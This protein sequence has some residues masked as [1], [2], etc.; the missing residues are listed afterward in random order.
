[1]WHYI[2]QVE[3]SILL[4]LQRVLV[5]VLHSQS[6]SAASLNPTIVDRF[7]PELLH[8]NRDHRSASLIER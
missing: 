4:K 3:D 1:M 7:H 8:L 5:L 6:V 2:S